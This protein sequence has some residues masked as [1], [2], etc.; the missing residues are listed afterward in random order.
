MKRFY[1]KKLKEA[2]V[3]EEYQLQIS[4]R[5]AATGNW[6]DNG[7]KIRAGRNTPIRTNI[8][9]SAQESLDQYERKTMVWWRMFHRF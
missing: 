9:I 5:F 2:E 4:N 6:G 1:L 3:R 7:D 8:K